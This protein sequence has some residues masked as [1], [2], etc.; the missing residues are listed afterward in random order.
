MQMP[1]TLLTILAL[2]LSVIG[3]MIKLPS[4]FHHYDKELHA[5]FYFLAAGFLNML[6]GKNLTTHILIFFVLLGF[7][8]AIE[9]AQAYSNILLKKRIHG[10]FDIED[11]KAN[12]KG[13]IA[14]SI[15]WIP[16]LIF[17]PSRQID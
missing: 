8:I 13:L 12:A 5:A 9:S 2:I 15:I 17:K 10:R 7:G 16:Y 11:V 4:V 6:Y 3:F 14:F 1:K